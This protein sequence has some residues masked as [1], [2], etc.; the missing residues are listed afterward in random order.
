MLSHEEAPSDTPAA[1]PEAPEPA[2]GASSV[3]ESTTRRGEDVVEREGKE[4]GRVDTGREDT[5][6]GRPTGTST[7]RDTTGINP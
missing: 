6:A 2:P 1:D 7:R 5:P 4:P 3:G